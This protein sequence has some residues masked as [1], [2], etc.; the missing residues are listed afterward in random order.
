MQRIVAVFRADLETVGDELV[1]QDP[2]RALAGTRF[3]RA[4][5]RLSPFSTTPLIDWINTFGSA[6]RQ[7]YEGSRFT[8]NVVPC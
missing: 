7:T 8:G 6:A 4:A 2:W 1:A 3:L 5:A